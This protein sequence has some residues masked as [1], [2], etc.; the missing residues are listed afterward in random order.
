MT[1]SLTL[2]YYYQQFQ[3]L[4]RIEC[5]WRVGRQRYAVGVG[6]RWAKGKVE[7]A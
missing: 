7:Q 3:E 5:L 1:Y 6:A 4:K 2:P